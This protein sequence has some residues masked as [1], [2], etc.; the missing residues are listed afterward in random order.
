MFLTARFDLSQDL[1]SPI[2]HVYNGTGQHVAGTD[3]MICL[4]RLERF[5]FVEQ[6]GSGSELSVPSGSAL[7]VPMN[8]ALDA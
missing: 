3:K 2:V 6:V 4:V 1:D 5:S 8:S 7:S